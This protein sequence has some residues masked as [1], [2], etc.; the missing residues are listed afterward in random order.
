[1]SLRTARRSF[2]VALALAAAV[3]LD[4]VRAQSTMWAG[5]YTERGL[6]QMPYFTSNIRVPYQVATSTLQTAV[7]NSTALAV[8]TVPTD[9]YIGYRWLQQFSALPV[10]ALAAVQ[11][12]A[13]EFDVQ[14]T[15]ASGTLGAPAGAVTNWII[16]PIQIIWPGVTQY[17]LTSVLGAGAVYGEID[18]DANSGS[19]LLLLSRMATDIQTAQWTAG[20]FTSPVVTYRYV[21]SRDFPG[22]SGVP[23]SWVADSGFGLT[24]SFMVYGYGNTLVN[25]SGLT[26]LPLGVNILN[27]PRFIV[28]GGVSYP[29]A[30][31]TTAPILVATTLPPVITTTTLPPPVVTTPAPAVTTPAPAVT[32]AAAAAAVSTTPQASPVTTAAPQAVTTTTATAAASSGASTGVATPTTAPKVAQTTTRAPAATTTRPSVAST[33]VPSSSSSSSAPITTTVAAATTQPPATAAP[34]T[35]PVIIGVASTTAAPPSP[36]TTTDVPTTGSG[37]AAT[38]THAPTSIPPES[39]SSLAQPN[40]TT[41]EPSNE[42]NSMG[43]AS[44][45]AAKLETPVVVVAIFASCIYMALFMLCASAL[46]L[47]RRHRGPLARLFRG[48]A[49]GDGTAAGSAL[50]AGDMYSNNNNDDEEIE[51]GSRATRNASIDTLSSKFMA[52]DTT[53]TTTTTGVMGYERPGYRSFPA[54]IMMDAR[55]DVMFKNE[56]TYMQSGTYYVN[57]HLP[58]SVGD[59]IARGSYSVIYEGRLLHTAVALRRLC[60]PHHSA[61][62]RTDGRNIPSLGHGPH[63]PAGE[64]GHEDGH[65]AAA[66]TELLLALH[67]VNVIRTLGWHQVALP[68]AGNQQYRVMELACYGSFYRLLAADSTLFTPLDLT[69]ACSH[70]CR[71]LAYLHRH[72]VIHRNLKPDAL[73][74]TRPYGRNEPLVIRIGSLEQ[75]RLLSWCTETRPWDASLVQKM[76]DAAAAS[77]SKASSRRVSVAATDGRSEYSQVETSEGPEQVTYVDSVSAF[78]SPWAAP[79][80]IYSSAYSKSS[81]IWSLSML[82]HGIWARAP[83]FVMRYESDLANAGERVRRQM[84]ICQGGNA[85]SATRHFAWLAELAVLRPDIHTMVPEC[86]SMGL[87]PEPMQRIDIANLWVSVESILEH[88]YEESGPSLFHVV[89]RHGTASSM[90]STMSTVQGRMDLLNTQVYPRL[91]RERVVETRT[92]ETDMLECTP[93]AYFESLPE[94]RK[95]ARVPRDIVDEQDDVPLGG[96]GGGGDLDGPAAIDDSDPSPFQRGPLGR[97]RVAFRERVRQARRKAAS[98]VASVRSAAGGGGGG[99]GGATENSGLVDNK[100]E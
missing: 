49:N 83:R 28:A 34:G 20:A 75:A 24:Y 5:Q 86:V 67:H 7:I 2:I 64:T 31:P 11:L 46:T 61:K 78:S 22:M 43:I 59:P 45:E 65:N 8:A 3:A 56:K 55:H 19:S 15:V 71:G 72:D 12:V 93:T 48:R 32:T 96:G 42:T 66:H 9:H 89:P 53:T 69:A 99:G 77:A 30:A 33:T 25:P 76:S 98:A 51:M 79:E 70:A 41:T 60:L 36:Q 92:V 37:D 54:E 81:D 39:S 94:R 35:D 10:P 91:H 74:L 82:M 26:P 21:F 58:F 23:R 100:F 4:G 97:M 52:T 16:N 27:G 62:G 29:T 84:E 57:S 80:V 1:M 68:R 95:Q 13:L 38:R 88:E 44:T 90:S 85:D 73:L 50:V 17:M 63:R 87:D 18:W 47:A 14:L 6:M 40:A